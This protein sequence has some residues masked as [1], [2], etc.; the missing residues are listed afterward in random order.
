MPRRL[1]GHSQG[2]GRPV[3][4]DAAS[5][6]KCRP[7]ALLCIISLSRCQPAPRPTARSGYA[8]GGRAGERAGTAINEQKNGRAREP[9]AE[10]GAD[11]FALA[12][13]AS[14]VAASN[15]WP[16]TVND[17]SLPTRCATS[18]HNTISRSGA[19]AAVNAP[20]RNCQTV[21]RV[22]M[23]VLTGAAIGVAA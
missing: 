2:P 14:S 6:A 23:L 13:Q 9:A 22:I 11:Y 16:A 10:R 1:R 3:R 12:L 7:N 17:D 21:S 8:M 5:G 4:I 19:L 18:W 20:S 15:A